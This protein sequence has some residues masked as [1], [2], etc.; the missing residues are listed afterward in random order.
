MDKILKESI[1]SIN[2][3][4]EYYNSQERSLYKDLDKKL[5][6]YKYGLIIGKFFNKLIENKGNIEPSEKEKT[7]LNDVL[8]NYDIKE[9][10]DGKLSVNYR[11]NKSNK[12]YKEYEL[13]PK[14]SVDKT[15]DLL[16]RSRI[17]DESILIMLL[18]KYEDT[19]SNIFRFILKKYPKI[20]LSD[21]SITYSELLSLDSGIDSIKET[22]VDKEID[23]L[24]RKPI[25]EWYRLLEE[26]Q[27]VCFNIDEDTH[28]DFIEIYYRRNI[29]VH[30]QGIVNEVYKNN[31]NS[32]T[33]IGDSITV[34]SDYLENAFIK[35]QIMIIA[36]VWG[37]RKITDDKK[38]LSEDLFKYGF[39]S[40]LSKKWEL[41][42]YVFN[43]L[44]QE[45]TN[46][47]ERLVNKINLWISK[48]NKYGLDSIKEEIEKLDVSSRDR[49]Y[50][51]AKSALL[52]KYDEVSMVLEEIIGKDLPAV[53]VE[54][55]PLFLQY[56]ESKQYKE[57]TKKHSDLFEV[58]GFESMDEKEQI[59]ETLEST[60]ESDG[61]NKEENSQKEIIEE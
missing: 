53:F 20:Y 50:I 4:K 60:I 45:E 32:E 8:D 26:K 13:D 49:R 19:I 15:Y 47:E 25:S 6:K 42:I 1:D 24:M 22:L 36:T 2:N 35:T 21:K 37:L 34:Y 40:M 18:I 46:E 12:K 11:L 52:D 51:M 28:N 29:I 27:K 17:L 38:Q 54:E 9:E 58:Q 5:S 14:K 44:L 57:F 41:A 39:N 61:N 3:L 30:N 7:I 10:K 33:D 31:T 55:W 16:T 23:S 59:I 48:K 56:R 43:S